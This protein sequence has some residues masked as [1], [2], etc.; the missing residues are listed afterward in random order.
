[1]AKKDA[2][3]GALSYMR[4][5][6]IL[7]TLTVS[8]ISLFHFVYHPGLCGTEEDS[9]AFL[10]INY[11]TVF[12]WPCLRAFIKWGYAKIAARMG[13]FE[14]KQ[15]E[16]AFWL[17]V[18]LGLLAV[19]RYIW[20]AFNLR[21]AIKHPK[22][23]RSDCN[24][25]REILVYFEFVYVIVDIWSN[26]RAVWIY[27][28]TKDEDDDTQV[29]HYGNVQ[30]AEHDEEEQSDVEEEDDEQEDDDNEEEDDDDSDEKNSD[31]DS[32]TDDNGGGTGH[33]G[34]QST[35]DESYEDD[36]AGGRTKLQQ[37]D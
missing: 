24:E 23:N 9:V 3:M 25:W 2:G 14:G 10:S 33:S 27:C 18:L 36:Y 21:F 32:D 31:K 17:G 11:T 1:M 5:I 15:M 34:N 29:V 8:I 13:Y 26:C 28:K 30:E 22:Y 4:I 6:I 19:R 12:L 7:G 35:S 16:Y 20:F 37:L